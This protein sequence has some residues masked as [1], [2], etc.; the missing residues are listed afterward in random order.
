[1]E[2]TY[3]NGVY[4]LQLTQC[5]VNISSY[6]G[7]TTTHMWR[8]LK[9]KIPPA[10]LLGQISVVSEKIHNVLG[11]ELGMSGVHGPVVVYGNSLGPSK[12]ERQV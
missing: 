4:L 2:F 9:V 1:M 3:T 12:T 6:G 8:D 5:I 7:N 11:T 10:G